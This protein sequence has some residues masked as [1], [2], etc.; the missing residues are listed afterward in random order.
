MRIRSLAAVVAILLAAACQSNPAAPESPAWF[1]A[2][3]AGTTVEGAISASYSGTGHF[4]TTDVRRPA[5]PPLV[6]LRS[7]G[8]GDAKDD[9]FEL[10]RA[11]LTLPAAGTYALGAGAN[12]FQAVFTQKR[13]SVTHRYAAQSG[14]LHITAAS[15][16]RIS[17]TFTFRG[18]FAGTCEG[19]GARVDCSVVAS[20]GPGAPAIDVQGSFVAV[21]ER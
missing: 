4:T 5:A 15:A 8:V 1:S 12:A 2:T 19:R 6:L 14:E 20:P 18:V 9:G 17:G 10:S 3:L 11:G 21:P 16:E 13:G 7:E